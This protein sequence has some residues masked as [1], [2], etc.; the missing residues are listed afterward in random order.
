[1]ARARGLERFAEVSRQLDKVAA[2]KEAL[3]EARSLRELAHLAL[4]S[5]ET[6]K[7]KTSQ[8]PR[9]KKPGSTS[10]GAASLKVLMLIGALVVGVLAVAGFW[11][12]QVRRSQEQFCVN[13]MRNLHS[14]AV[15]YCLERKLGPDS[16]VSVT[17]LAA[18]VPPSVTAC[19]RARAAYPSF[20]VLQGP[21]CPSGHLYERGVPRPLKATDLKTAALYLNFG[22]TH[23]ITPE[24]AASRAAMDNEL[25]RADTNRTRPETGS[26]E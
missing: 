16:I 6:R 18:Y 24:A 22:L 7:R 21:S 8:A 1:M 13:H 4:T 26:S 2:E 25:A 11:S 9:R 14:V 10:S 23:L 17:D 5:G 20:S 3:S 15:S 19:P 12:L